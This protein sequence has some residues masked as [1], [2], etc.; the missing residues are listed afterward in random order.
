MTEISTITVDNCTNC[1]MAQSKEYKYTV[2]YSCNVSETY[3]TVFNDMEEDE[4]KQ[5]QT[6]FFCP[7]RN[8]NVII[9]LNTHQNGN[10]TSLES[11]V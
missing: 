2:L 5:L 8:G 1:P 3:M 11:P 4:E 9:K 10:E 6:P 7:L